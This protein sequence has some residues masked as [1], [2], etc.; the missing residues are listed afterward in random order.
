MNHLCAKFDNQEIS[1]GLFG[2]GQQ[3]YTIVEVTQLGI[4]QILGH[5]RPLFR[6]LRS[7]V[8]FTC[9]LINTFKRDVFLTLPNP[10]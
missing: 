9:P 3:R 8:V 6:I 7:L 10:L 5:F 4:K 1:R 2:I